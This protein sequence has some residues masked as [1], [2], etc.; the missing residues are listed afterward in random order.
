MKNQNVPSFSLIVRSR[1]EDC[2]V[3]VAINITVSEVVSDRCLRLRSP[4]PFILALLGRLK[5]FADFVGRQNE[6]YLLFDKSRTWALVL[7]ESD[8]EI[9]ADWRPRTLWDVGVEVSTYWVVAH[10]NQSSLSMCGPREA[11]R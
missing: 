9:G 1:L 4:Q 5:M 8:V 11:K 7:F 10:D 2:V 3:L 6:T